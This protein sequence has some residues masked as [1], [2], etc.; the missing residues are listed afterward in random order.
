M[1]VQDFRVISKFPFS[2]CKV[3]VAVVFFGTSI[4]FLPHRNL[5]KVTSHY[6][7]T[8]RGIKLSKD[9]Q[10]NNYLQ[11]TRFHRFVLFFKHLSPLTFLFNWLIRRDVLLLKFL[12]GKYPSP[13]GQSI[14]PAFQLSRPHRGMRWCGDHQCLLYNLWCIQISSSDCL[15]VFAARRHQLGFCTW[16]NG[17]RTL[18]TRSQQPIQPHQPGIKRVSNTDSAARSPSIILFRSCRRPH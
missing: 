14:E 18:L 1:L 2:F 13:T 15:S 9:A 10:S 7:D 6:S 4:S 16:M 5:W 11:T 17:H 12:T 3:R 8:Y